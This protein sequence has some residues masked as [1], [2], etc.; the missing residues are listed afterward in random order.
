MK[1]AGVIGAESPSPRITS[2]AEFVEKLGAATPRLL[3]AL[4]HKF[5]PA[6][7]KGEPPPVHGPLLRVR[8]RVP[9]H[10][11]R[12]HEQADEALAG[13]RDLHRLHRHAA[14][15]QG[16]ADDAGRVR[17]LHPHLQVPRGRGRRRHPGPQVRGPRRAAA[18]DLAGRHRRVVRAEDQGAEQLPEGGAPQALGDDGGADERR[19]AQAAHHRRHH[20]GLQPQAAAEQR[21]RHGDPGRGVDLRRLPLL[22]AASEHELRPVLRDHH[23]VRAE[24]QRHL[25]RAGQQRRALQVRHLHAAR[26]QGRAR[27]PSSTRTR[28]SAASSRSRRT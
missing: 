2:R 7:L 25:A 19:R 9:P 23:L 13:R 21:P 4:I 22:P 6:D 3:C 20:R 28:P 18:A 5:D 8:G 12:R 17:H 1:N 10:P 14:P 16:Q 27:P 26:P 11:G 24:P 15:A